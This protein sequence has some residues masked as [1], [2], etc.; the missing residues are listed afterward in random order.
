MK[1][2]HLLRSALVLLSFVLQQQFALSQCQ[3]LAAGS[4]TVGGASANFPTLDSALNRLRCAGVNGPITLQLAAG[5][6][7]GRYVLDSLPGTP[8]R[9]RI[10]SNGGAVF[11][12]GASVLA[13][14]SFVMRGG[15]WE[16]VQLAF[17]RSVQLLNNGPMVRIQGGR[18]HR[19]SNN[20]FTDRSYGPYPGGIAILYRGGDSL[21]VDS[22]AFSGW[23]R[24]FYADSVSQSQALVFERNLIEEYS[25]IALQ[26]SDISSAEIRF[27]HFRNAIFRRGAPIA[28]GFIECST[29][30]VYGNRITGQLPNVGVGWRAPRGSQA[31][32]NQFYNNE[33][34]G[35]ASI[36]PFSADYNL[37]ELSFLASGAAQNLVI[38]HNTMRIFH[39]A[40]AQ[41]NSRVLAIWGRPRNIDSMSV[42]SNLLVEEGASLAHSSL[43]HQFDTLNNGFGFFHNV[44]WKA[45]TTR[46]FKRG[47]I[48]TGPYYTG[49]QQWQLLTGRDLGARVVNPNWLQPNVLFRPT[50]IA[51]DNAGLVTSWPPTDITGLIRGSIPDAGAREFEPVPGE[52]QLGALFVNSSGCVGSS[53]ASLQFAVQNMGLTT[54]PSVP[55]SLWVNGVNQGSMRLPALP[56]GLVDTLLFPATINLSTLV[57]YQIVLR[58]DT[59]ADGF[60]GNDTARLALQYLGNQSLP[61]FDDFELASA[62]SRPAFEMQRVLNNHM[63]WRVMRGEM[64]TYPYGPPSDANGNPN[65]Q[66]LGTAYFGPSSGLPITDTLGFEYPCLNLSGFTVPQLSFEVYSTTAGTS[67]K[68]QQ[69]VNGIWQSLDSVMAAPQQRSTDAWVLRRSF[70]NPLADA[71]RFLTMSVFD[72]LFSS[73]F[74]D[75]VRI[76]EL[77]ETDL[78]LDSVVIQNNSCSNSG[79]AT[80]ILYLRNDGILLLNGVRGGI[81]LG[82]AAPVFRTAPRILAPFSTDTVHITIPYNALGGLPGKA[83]AANQSD[84]FFRG[85]TLAFVLAANGQQAT[86]PYLENFEQPSGWSIGGLPSSWELAAPA[87]LALLP[88]APGNKAWVTTADGY[89]RDLELSWLQSPCFDFTNLIRPQLSFALNYELGDGA[90]FYVQYRS[91]NTGPWQVLGS[92]FS[93]TNWFNSPGARIGWTGNSNGW[94]LASHDLGFLAGQNAVQ[95]RLVFDNQTDSNS[96]VSRFE[97]VA[98]DNF[99]IAEFPGSFAFQ[100]NITPAEAC[101]PVAHTVITRIA[102]A[103]QLQEARVLY[104]VNGGAEV[105]LP[106]A[107]VGLDYQ[108]IIPAQPAGSLVSWRIETLSDTLLSTQASFYTDGYLQQPARPDQTGPA[109]TPIS[110][111]TNM[112][113]SGDLAVAQGNTDSARGA[114]LEIEALRYTEIEA[115][116]V[117]PT[118]FTAIEVYGQIINPAGDSLRQTQARL[119]ASVRGVGPGGSNI[120]FFSQ[121]P[122]LWPGQKLLLYVV[123]EGDK[124]LRVATANAG[125]QQQDAQVVVRP[126]RLVQ[127]KFGAQ[128]ALG[129]PTARVISRNPASQVFWRSGSGAILGQ[130]NEFTT[131]ID[132][133]PS[134][135]I[136]HLVRGLCE[137]RDTIQLTPTGRMNLSVTQIL[138]PNLATVQ[139]G[140]FYPVRVVV[141]N[142]GNLPVLDFRL[143]YKSNGLELAQSQ[144]NRTLAVNDTMHFTF[145][146]LWTWVEG[147]GITLCAYP[148]QF[149]LDVQRNDDT[150]CLYRFP[151]SVEEGAFAGFRL[152]PV[153]TN[154]QVFM[155][156]DKPLELPASLQVYDALGRQVMVRSFEA[157]ESHFEFDLMG[158]SAGMYHYRMQSG[159]HLKVGKLLLQD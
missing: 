11:S 53:T 51:A 26:L 117:Q 111:N 84:V 132:T 45:D 63:Q 73:W 5:N 154:G 67:L 150:T 97:G 33:I 144:V 14:E 156:L 17:E 76:G 61:R 49:L 68:V 131:R 138:E 112:A 72:P 106:L 90:R 83:F 82:N 41:Q 52:L 151:T 43:V 60:A 157:G 31:A 158:L 102:R 9:I 35:I 143:A 110:F 137:F 103:N 15:R 16:L 79:T 123:T 81:Q 40:G 25:D 92:T 141:Q 59:L 48:I 98:F 12:R 55:L 46:M 135:V 21:R 94:L 19:L 145:P 64:N 50:A 57:N 66:Y 91:G 62:G 122:A 127:G 65:G 69:R 4:Y 105:A 93:G 128:T 153:P 58:A 95:F 130:Q 107:P 42:T 142:K 115:L 47:S 56:A 80:G 70:I 121:R 129:W 32:P 133:L 44:Y 118:A 36:E 13:A 109:F 114:W 24:V 86:Y 120:L 87:G 29:L 37:V 28:M 126:G 99:R 54:L 2:F 152:Y 116:W 85:D 22:N 1:S 96:I 155:T 159:N 139:Q 100:T 78:V 136:M 104:R 134:Q 39:P 149:N 3:P 38:A 6:Y 34:A 125:A 119:L 74:V 89:T 101:S 146:Q 20:R 148:A 108:T 88:Q 18:Q 10:Q 77:V 71:I 75:N 113:Q 27:N 23:G 7:T 124:H 147:T 30:Q 8:H 140:V